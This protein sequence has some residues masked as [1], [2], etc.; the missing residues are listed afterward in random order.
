MTIM[1]NAAAQ[2]S[3][4]TGTLPSVTSTSTIIASTQVK[5]KEGISSSREDTSEEV[6]DG[7]ETSTMRT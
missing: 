6:V 7:E 5:E 4:L 3:G 1:E 2:G